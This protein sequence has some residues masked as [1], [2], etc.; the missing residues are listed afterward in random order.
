MMGER[1]GLPEHTRSIIGIDHHQFRQP[2]AFELVDTGAAA[3][4]ELV[5]ILLWSMR[6]RITRPIAEDILTSIIVETNS[7]RLPKV[8]PF[9]FAV[10]AELLKTGVDFRALVNM[11][12][13]RRSRASVLLLGRC[14]ERASFLKRN[15]VIWSFLKKK[16][17]GRPGR[18]KRTPTLLSRRC[19]RSPAS[20]SRCFSGNRRT[21]IAS[22]CGRGAGAMWVN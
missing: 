11:V 7:F 4:G 13:W 14:L 6:A 1:T 15:R 10:C 16:T 22:A 18:K 20:K 17:S 5:Y 9:T 12:Y 21:A 8:R 19:V 2:F 3:V